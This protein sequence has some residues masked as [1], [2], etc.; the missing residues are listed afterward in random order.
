[1]TAQD[2]QDLRDPGQEFPSI[3]GPGQASPAREETIS[4]DA[5]Q[6]Q[7]KGKGGPLVAGR[8]CLVIV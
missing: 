4:H 8:P 5:M 3:L 7:R 6:G 2:I 1:M